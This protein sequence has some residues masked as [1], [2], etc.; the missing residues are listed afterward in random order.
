M[1]VIIECEA[2]QRDGLVVSH[3][4]TYVHELSSGTPLLVFFFPQPVSPLTRGPVAVRARFR[5]HP[6]KVDDP[7][8]ICFIHSVLF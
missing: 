6:L 3:S 5:H 2:S 4:G 8:F 1:D 7:S